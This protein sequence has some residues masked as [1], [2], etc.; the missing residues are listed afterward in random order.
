MKTKI[1]PSSCRQLG[2]IVL[3]LLSMLAVSCGT[4]E[5][6][7]EDTVTPDRATTESIHLAEQ[8]V[9]LS[10]T[11]APVPQEEA[12]PTMTLTSPPP[13]LVYWTDGVLWKVDVDG[14]PVPI[15]SPGGDHAQYTSW[16]MNV[17]I[18]PGG[19]HVLYHDRETDDLWLADL[20]TGLQ[21]N[22]TNTPDTSER[23]FRWWPGRPGTILFG[24]LSRDLAPGPGWTGFLGV[25]GSQ[26]DGYRILD[27][28]HHIGGPPA[29]SPDG[30][31][32]AYG[33]GNAAW[34]YHWETGL[35]IF[36]PADYGLTAAEGGLGIGS[37]AWSPDGKRLAWMV[38]G[39]GLSPDGR[40]GIVVFD[41]ETRTA[42]LLHS[43]TPPGLEGWLPTPIWREDGYLNM[44]GYLPAPLWSP[45][46]RWLA[47]VAL[48]QNPVESILWALQ[49]DGQ[50]E[51][52]IPLAIGRVDS[53][54]WSPDGRWLIFTHITEESEALARMVEVE[55]GLRHQVDLSPDA[56]IVDWLE[57]D[58]TPIPAI[59]PTSEPLPTP[60][61]TPELV[62]PTP[63]CRPSEASVN[64]SVSAV[65][66][67]VGQVISVTVTL[68]NGD[69]T[70]ARLGEI[71]YSLGVE[72]A[73]ILIGDSLGPVR[74]PLSLEP[75][76]SD[77]V[78]FVLQAATPGQVTLTGSTSFEI[79]ALDY[80]SASWSG[81][82]SWPLEIIVT[83]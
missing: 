34:L 1:S 26:G 52:K 56:V 24:S 62:P 64:L 35:E 57:M 67:E 16:Q 33:G 28:Q 83:P 82:R 8:V 37:P 21:R 63:Y 7:I 27:D 78:E 18:S 53:L 20:T 49:T 70:D 61:V 68:V 14:Q 60:D 9:T 46:G 23:F 36:D 22:L 55:T 79:H 45:D 19:D 72:P 13:G 69:T 17:R 11:P 47:S 12:S 76:Q 32:V 15:F 66:L 31:T 25:V 58:Q 41:L 59:S 39:E 40:I 3:F 5:I 73:N 43:Y 38:E 81:C 42:R 10:A 51:R 44:Y 77:E 80:S 65:T 48:A 2:T 54:A 50:A 74:H 6:D 75:G 29:P 71:L 4:L 30:Q